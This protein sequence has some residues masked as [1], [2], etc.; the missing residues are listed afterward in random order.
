MSNC[1]VFSL[2]VV[3]SGRSRVARTH[4]ASISAR[5][6]TGAPRTRVWCGVGAGLV[7]GRLGWRMCMCGAPT[8]GA[9]VSPLRQQEV[10]LHQV[11]EVCRCERPRAPALVH[12][13]R[14]TPLEHQL[15]LG[16]SRAR[17]QAAPEAA[18]AA[19]HLSLR[20]LLGPYPTEPSP[21][22]HSTLCPGVLHTIVFN[23]ALGHVRPVDVDSELFD[24]TYVRGAEG[25]AGEGARRPRWPAGA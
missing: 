15:G 20:G 23:R 14:R 18:A 22:E 6:R 5:T 10:E 9:C 12:R 11:R 19:W 1:E 17:S 24:V 4:Q 16:W 7:Q 13:E 2:P 21:L 25:C 8:V 3:V